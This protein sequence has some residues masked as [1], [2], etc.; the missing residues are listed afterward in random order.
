[1][2]INEGRAAHEHAARALEHLTHEHWTFETLGLVRFELGQAY[3]KLKKHL[4]SG[5]CVC[6]DK[7]E[8]L[9]FYKTLLI[10]INNAISTATLR[11]V[12]VVQEEL[13]SFLI[14]RKNQ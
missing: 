13:H 8:D 9:E 5:K 14:S 10:D 2:P 12:P 3:F 1:M 7:P 11:V 4:K 6:G